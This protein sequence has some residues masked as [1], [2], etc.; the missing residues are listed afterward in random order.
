M[1]TKEFVKNQCEIGDRVEDNNTK[2]LGIVIDLDIIENV[3]GLEPRAKIHW[4]DC[5]TSLIGKL[6]DGWVCEG[7]LT[8]LNPRKNLFESKKNVRVFSNPVR[9]WTP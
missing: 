2:S 6:E 9:P 5:S 4:T 1:S 3:G 8:I 7:N